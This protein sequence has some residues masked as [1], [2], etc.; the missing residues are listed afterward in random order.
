MECGKL[1]SATKIM[2][3]VNPWYIKVIGDRVETT[4]EWDKKR[5]ETLYRGI[6]AKFD[7]NSPLKRSLLE[8]VGVTAS[9]TYITLVV[10]GLIRRNGIPLTGQEKM[11]QAKF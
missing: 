10:L 11:S 5:M 7:Q 8:T 6:F 4:E 9:Q 2:S 1:T 3:K